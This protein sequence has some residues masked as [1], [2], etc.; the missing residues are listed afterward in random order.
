MEKI[1]RIIARISIFIYPVWLQ[2][3]VRNQ[4]DKIYTW[5]IASQFKS[6][7]G[8]GELNAIYMFGMGKI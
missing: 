5:R 1:F 8:G 3:K 2:N 6:F 4:F 7:M